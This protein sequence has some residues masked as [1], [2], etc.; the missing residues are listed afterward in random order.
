[1]TGS[2]AKDADPDLPFGLF[3]LFQLDLQVSGLTLELTIETGKR[4]FADAVGS[5][6][7]RRANAP[8]VRNSDGEALRHNA[9]LGG[10]REK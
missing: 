9:Q 10:G 2:D 1:M 3:E 6:R 4:S 8:P 5:D 7:D